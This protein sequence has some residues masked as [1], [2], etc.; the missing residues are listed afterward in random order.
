MK[1]SQIEAFRAV[2]LSGSM[3]AAA[4]HLHTSQ[5]NISRLIAQLEKETSLRLFER[6]GA[7]LMPT[8][9]GTAFFRDVERAFV[10]LQ[11]LENSA[12]GIRQFGT[13]RL[14]IATVSA[15]ATALLPH[16]IKR[17]KQQYPDVT[18]SMHISDSLTVAHWTASQFCDF[19]VASYIG[20]TPGVD[21]EV[22]AKVQGM[23]IMAKGHRL[24]DKKVIKPKDLN[25]E[26]FISLAHGDGTRAIIDRAFQGGGDKRILSLEASHADTICI[27]VGLGIGV[28]IVS[29][30]VAHDYMSMGLEMR[31]FSPNIP[32]TNYL[33]CPQHR[34]RSSLTLRFAEL[35]AELLKERLAQWS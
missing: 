27:M 25:D 20:D 14:R 15:T 31:P 12:H 26:H 34:P 11:S 7:R 23:C 28:S 4:E 32:F 35:T 2:M 22:L 18:I 5:P 17:F 1:F 30:L 8:D 33:L 3:T 21:V 13:G 6:A 19:G 24:A 9:E 16:V 10:G 29:P